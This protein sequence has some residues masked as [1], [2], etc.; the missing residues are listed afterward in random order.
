MKI[1]G[2]FMFVTLALTCSFAQAC[3]PAASYSSYSNYSAESC[4]SCNGEG[5]ILAPSFSPYVGG[6]CVGLTPNVGYA[7]PFV[8]TGYAVPFASAGYGYR[9][10]AGVRVNPFVGVR[11]D[12]CINNGNVHGRFR[13]H[14][15]GRY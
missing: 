5:T 14:F 13:G 7:S 8:S 3:P 2:V 1:F 10:F 11:V 12:P 4:G 15:R 9:S 6:G